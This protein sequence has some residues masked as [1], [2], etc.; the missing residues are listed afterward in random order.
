MK[1]Q[2]PCLNCKQRTANCHSKCEEYAYF[3][4]EL[5]EYNAYRK[6]N[7]QTDNDYYAVRNRKF[8]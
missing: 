4:N 8:K 7:K 2:S 3:R 6:K 1:P 5:D